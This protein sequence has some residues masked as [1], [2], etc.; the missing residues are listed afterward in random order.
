M[1]KKTQTP[2]AMTIPR[3]NAPMP[4]FSLARNVEE[5]TADIYI[6]GDIAHNRGGLSGLLQS[7]SDQSSYDLANQIAGIPEDYTIT[8]HIN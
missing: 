1:D 4:Y 7:S 2:T 3:N 5:K 6:F 8:L